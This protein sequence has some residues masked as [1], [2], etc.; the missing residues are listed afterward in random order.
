MQATRL[1]AQPSKDEDPRL[2][3]VRTFVDRYFRSWSDQD[4]NT[5]DSCFLPEAV[6]QFIDDRGAITSK[7]KTRFVSEQREVHRRSVER[8]VEVPESVEVR[9]EGRLAHAVVIWK[10]TSGERVQKGYD[11]FTL[12]KREGKWR[13]VNLT[14][15]ATAMEE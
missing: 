8:N 10:L 11:H 1:E 3:E 4:M 13:I 14:F 5:Y 7:G 9:L 6:I 12:L 15:Y 2:G